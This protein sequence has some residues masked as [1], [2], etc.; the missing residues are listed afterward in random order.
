MTACALVLGSGSSPQVQAGP[1]LVALTDSAYCVKVVQPP[2][3]TI[4]ISP[5]GDLFLPGTLVTAS[6]TPQPGYLLCGWLG[7]L[8]GTSQTLIFAVDSDLVVGAETCADPGH[9]PAGRLVPVASIA[10]LRNAV[11]SAL[12]GDVIE[13]AEGTYADTGAITVDRGGVEGY[14]VDIRAR[15]RGQ[16]VL[17]GSLRFEVRKTAWVVLEGLVFEST[18]APAV[19]IKASHHV[20]VTR[21]VFR[22]HEQLPGNW[23]LIDGGFDLPEPFSHH[24]RVDHNRFEDKSQSGNFVTIRG[25]SPPDARPSQYDRIDRNHFRGTGPRLVNGKEAIRVGWSAMSRSSGFTTIE[26]NLFEDCDGD[27]EIISIKTSDD[28]VRFNTIR[29]SQGT[30]TLR[31]G[32]RN[33]VHGNFFFGDGKEGTGGVRMYGDDHLVYNNYFEGLTGTGWD[34]PLTVPN[35]DADYDISTDL[36]R[37]Y[38]ARRATIAFNTFVD[39]T[40][41]LEIGHPG[42][43]FALPPMDVTLEHD[44]VVGDKANLVTVYTQPWA[45]S[46]RGNLMWPTGTATLGIAASPAEIIV[47]DPMLVRVAGLWRIGAGSPLIDAAGEDLTFA[48]LD[49]DGQSRITSDIGA[50]EYSSGLVAMRPLIP[51]DVGPDGPEE[52]LLADVTPGSNV[53]PDVAALFP[54]TPNPFTLSTRIRF[55]L[56]APCTVDLAIYDVTGRRR[57]VL[58]AGPLP[59]G[60]H[61]AEWRAR[62]MAAGVYL[63]RLRAGAA[64]LTRKLVRLP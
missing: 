20:R 22:L 26:T 30:V 11:A 9:P 23:V 46:W 37:H 62:E 1:E 4:L 48:F 54:N 21:N 8:S 24:N 58:I 5:P 28:V 43:G 42:S 40:H 15:T 31:H 45:L 39:N 6:F 61:Q 27:P 19:E 55:S 12:P 18:A 2:V 49:M 41:G 13:I 35:G 57:A 10:G 3:G 29:H 14:P 34:A 51:G 36:S 32:D 16:V 7:A 17:A 63:C 33:T 52:T 60:P 38:R 44:L 53:N 64:T 25:S 47:A 50:D 59:A 56:P